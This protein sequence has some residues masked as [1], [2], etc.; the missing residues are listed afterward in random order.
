MTEEGGDQIGSDRIKSD[1][2]I[3][4]VSRTGKEVAK[5]FNIMERGEFVSHRV[6]LCHTIACHAPHI[7][8][9]FT[10]FTHFT[11]YEP[12]R[13]EKWRQEKKFPPHVFQLRQ[14]HYNLT[15]DWFC[16][17][18]LAESAGCAAVP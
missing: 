16:V 2:K 8:H 13:E 14:T 18:A 11:L 15:H 10:L 17:T 9:I 3:K 12:R 7:S 5:N 6:T 4:Q 1:R